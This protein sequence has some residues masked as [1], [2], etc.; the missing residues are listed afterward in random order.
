MLSVIST[1]QYAANPKINH[2]QHHLHYTWVGFQPSPYKFMALGES[3]PLR[4]GFDPHA[5]YMV[6]SS[7]EITVTSQ[8]NLSILKHIEINK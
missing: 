7:T 8:M 6:R 4:D 2:L 3:P 1:I 5:S